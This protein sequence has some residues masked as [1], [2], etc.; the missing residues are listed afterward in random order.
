M[1]SSSEQEIIIKA[2]HGDT[3]AFRWLVERYQGFAY[4]LAWR[5]T[6]EAASAEDIVQEAF[7]RVWKNL[8]RY[9]AEIK[10]STWLYKIVTNLALDFLRSRSG[11]Q[12]RQAVSPERAINLADNQPADDAVHR[13]ELL[14]AI[15]LL[16][17]ALSPKQRAVFILRDLEGLSVEEVSDI[18][19]MSAGNIKSNL[20]HA[21]SF[22]RE[23]LMQYYREPVKNK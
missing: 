16:A 13:E 2:R 3:A 18:L 12:S 1:Q 11:K 4:S 5:F 17:E 14:Q 19:S 22:M 10:L 23:K 9:R 8:P 15:L 21:R 7:I 6:G 20:H